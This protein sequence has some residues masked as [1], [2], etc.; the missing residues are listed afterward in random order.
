MRR[1]Y[2][3]LLFATGQRLYSTIFSGAKFITSSLCVYTNLCLEPEKLHRYTWLGNLEWPRNWHTYAQVSFL[4]NVQLDNGYCT[5]VSGHLT[6]GEISLLQLPQ[7]L[8]HC[9][10]LAATICCPIRA[11]AGF[12]GF[13]YFCK[14]TPNTPSHIPWLRL[15]HLIFF[16]FPYMDS[17]AFSRLAPRAQSRLRLFHTRLHSF[18]N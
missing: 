4:F 2:F 12:N 13:H 6:T 11:G 7:V 18:K 5:M 1:F 14:R 3:C 10:K 9:T 17:L 8:S 16:P 15:H